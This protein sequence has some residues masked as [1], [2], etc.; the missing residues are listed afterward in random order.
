MAE[1]RLC[2]NC[3]ARINDSNP[4]SVKLFLVPVVEGRTK[5]QFSNYSGHMDIG[6][7]CAPKVTGWRWQRRKPRPHQKA[8]AANGG[9]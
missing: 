8:V 4:M 5:Q 7:C 9:R 6:K 1:V 2:D 3:G